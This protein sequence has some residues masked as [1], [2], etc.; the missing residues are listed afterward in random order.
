[1][2]IPIQAIT[3]SAR[4]TSSSVRRYP[5]H[6]VE[7]LRDARTLRRP[8]EPLADVSSFH[9]YPL[10]ACWLGHATVLL[11]LGDTTILTDPVFSHRIGMRLPGLTVGV[12]RVQPPALDVEHLPDIDIVLISHAHFDHLD[13]PSLTRLARGP[14]RNAAVV[15]AARTRRLIPRGFDNVIELPWDRR[16]RVRDVR[17]SALRPAH[18]GA[19]TALDHHRGFNAYLLESAGQSIFF[20]GDTAYTDAFDSLGSTNLSIFGIG[21]YDPWENAHATPEQA[22]SMFARQSQAR[23]H[24][25]PMHHST[26]ALGREPAHEP[27]QRLAAA[28]GADP[29]VLPG[30]LGHLWT[31]RA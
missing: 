6:V 10:A 7:S 4:A 15:T 11:K 22:Y 20:A 19:R 3:K 17:L 16:A 5:R 8:V 29:R 18:W 2:A 25:L 27:L 21:A 9:G 30:D 13:R 1:M 28:A 12:P 14:A 31:P 24:M 26:F 23:G